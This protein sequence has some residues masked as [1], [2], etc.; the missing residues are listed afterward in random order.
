MNYIIKEMAKEDSY[1]YMYVN[2]IS[3]NETYRGIIN[4]NFLDKIMN[5]LDQNAENQ[6]NKFDNDK[7]NKPNKKRFLLYVDGEAA[8]IFSIENSREEMY[9]NSG[10]LTSIYLLNKFQKQGLG[11]VMF[12]R[13]KKELK[14]LGFSNM[15]ICCIKENPT[16]DFYKYVGGQLM[17]EK[18]KNIGGQDLIENVYYFEKI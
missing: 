14:K 17:Y 7:I 12:E 1:D 5:E 18:E 10:E 6:K 8:G 9:V 2:T 16:N 3:W 11:R 4:D 13:A 15:I